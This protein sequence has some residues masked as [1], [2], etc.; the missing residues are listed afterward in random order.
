VP[1]LRV[2]DL[3][4]RRRELRETLRSLRDTRRQYAGIVLSGIGGAGKSA[5][6]GRVMCRLADDGWLVAAHRGRFDLAAIAVALG[7]AL[8]QSGREP[9]RR[10]GELLVQTNLD[11]RVRL[12]ARPRAGTVEHRDHKAAQRVGKTLEF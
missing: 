12:E 1:Q 11:D 9:M 5:V 10:R 4:G 7:S 3:I 6:A 2:D 8:L